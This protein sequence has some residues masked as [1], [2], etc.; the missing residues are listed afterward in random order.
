MKKSLLTSFLLT[1]MMILGGATSWADE[2]SATLDHTAGAQWGSNTGASTVDAEKEHYNNDAAGSWAGCAYAKFSFAIP[3]GHSIT[4]AKLTYS[5]NQGGKSGRNDIIYYM[6]KDFDLDWANFAGQTG[7]DLRNAGSRAGKAVASAATG[8]TGDRLNLQQDVTDAVKAIYDAGQNYIIFQWTGNA[9]GADLYGKTSAN[10]PTLVITTA[11]A[12]SVTTYTVKFTDGTNDLKDAKV[13]EGV[14]IG[15]EQTASANDMASFMANDKKWIYQ[16]GNETITTVADAASNVIT[17]VF[18]EA[19]T[20]NYSLTDATTSTVVAQGTGFEADVIPAYYPHYILK[21]NVLYECPK[22][23]SNPWYGVNITL[24]NTDTEKSINYTATDIENVVFVSEGEAL[25]GASKNTGNY[26]DIRSFGGCVG[27]AATEDIVIANLP[28]GKYKIK[29][30]LFTPTSAMGSQKIKVGEQVLTLTSTANGYH[31]EIETEEFELAAAT[32]IL[33][34]AGGSGTN[35]VDWLYIQKTGDYEAPDDTTPLVLTFPKYNDASVGSYTAEWTANVAGKVWTFNGFNNNSNKWAYV[36][37]GRKSYE[38]V[39]T[40]TSPAVNAVIKNVVFTVDATA[41]VTEAGLTILN[42]DVQVD[43]INI[44]DKFAK[45]DVVI[46]VDGAKGYAYKLTVNSS[47]ASANG[48]TQ[49]SK[50]A[51]YA[52]GEYVADEPI[53]NTLE[54]A[55][56]V[57]KAIELIDAGKSLSDT[58]Y[59]KGVVKAITEVSIEHNNATFA[60]ADDPATEVEMT[61]FRGVGPDGFK[62]TEETKDVLQVSDTVI[63][64]GLLQK[65]NDAYQFTQG[66][67]IVYLYSPVTLAA[68]DSLKTLIDEATALEEAKYTAETWADL[69]T[70]ITAAQTAQD[71]QIGTVSIYRNAY[72]AL[73]AA[74][75]A[76][77]A[78][79]EEPAVDD[80]VIDL[81]ADMFFT[82]DGDG[83]DAVKTSNTPATVDFKLGEEVAAGT[84]IVGTGSVLYLTYADITGATKLLFEGKA[85][86]A[87][88]VLMNRQESNSG[89]LVEKTLSIADNGKAELD[90]TDLPYVHINAIKIPY[91]GSTGNVITSIKFVKPGDP[92]ALPKEALKNAIGAAKL[93]NPVAKTE[94]SYAAL[95]AAILAAEAALNAADA[96]ETSLAKAK[97]GLEA[98]QAALTLAEGYSNLTKD[99]FFSHTTQG[100]E[101]TLNAGCA[102]VLKETSGLP[103]GLST[104][105]WL[106]YADLSAY[107]KLYITVADGAPRFCF[108]RIENGGQ[109]N[110]D[111][112]LSKMID[113]PNN[114]RSTAAYQ[115]VEGKTYIIDLA[116]MVDDKG[117]SYLHC[118]K[119][120]NYGNVTITGMYLYKEEQVTEKPVTFDFKNSTHAA[121]QDVGNI[122]D[123][124]IEQDGVVLSFTDGST[125]TR[126]WGSE[127]N[128][129]LR[130]YKN[131]GTMKVAAPE[132]KA[133]TNIEFTCNSKFEFTAKPE[134]LVD[135]TW[136]GNSTSVLFTATN[137]TQLYAM[138]VTLADKNAETVEPAEPA[139]DE[140]IANTQETAYT[141]AKAMELIDA[142]KSLSDTVFV[143]G[144]IKEIVKVNIEENYITFVIA[145]DT[146]STTTL[147][148]CYRSKCPFTLTEEVK[149]VLQLGDSVVVK[150]TLLKYNDEYELNRDNQIVYLYS[151]VTKAA[152]DSLKTLIDEATALEEAKYTAETWADL[153]TAITAAQTAQDAQIGTVSIYRNAYAT[154]KAAIDALEAKPEVTHTWDFTKWSEET[155]TNLKADA[156]ASK[157][158]GWSDIEKK[159]VA[160][161]DGEPTDLSRDNCF[162]FA[163]AANDDNELTANGVVIEE[164]K[165]LAFDNATYNGKRSL[166]IAV[167]YAV[168]DAAKDFGPYHGPSYLWLGGGGKSIIP[169][170]TIKNVKPGTEIKMGVESHKITDARGVQL[171]ISGA[172]IDG[173]AAPTTYV[174]QTW[175]IPAGEA[176][177]DVVV[178]NTNGCHIYFI[179][180]EI[181]EAPIVDGISTLKAAIEEGTVYNLNGQKVEKPARG[182]YII[183]GKKVVIK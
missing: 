9:G 100:D 148:K 50:V 10:A 89:P 65:Y 28:A 166:A 91:N 177:V 66:N 150:G 42:G 105:D 64:K 122:G 153:Q 71:A 131:G 63:V 116:K 161:A 142:G 94:E 125:K 62:F 147:L 18:R 49:I 115:T 120:A 170:F 157:T 96:T 57:A 124:T 127:G 136:T 2:V 101:G 56:T 67:Q 126:F 23:G 103:Y 52:D 130:I 121:G 30:D 137:T 180:A 129:D 29:A 85:G 20:V 82:W 68:K 133:I 6:A 16:S 118:I 178:Q 12:S 15:S 140:P 149:D 60:I 95:Q 44:T 55:Y 48:P 167:N 24:G 176:V 171:L 119:G 31:N 87:L 181:G 162:W 183:N 40:I 182:L 152:K 146:T 51:L 37:C 70:A 111:E 123:E 156:A 47:A 132:N 39:A 78:K 114:S 79:A 27:Y 143:A 14:A 106:N 25:T 32:D 165:G 141:V 21:E 19:A 8:G 7:T 99:L 36:K 83:A 175:T 109:D 77:E 92:L 108:N 45:G 11:D 139:V 174:E 98:A 4:G 72:A 58:V 168:V 1:L 110:D 59:V 53:A 13:Y 155:V 75:D 128:K 86:T 113:I 26:A 34:A 159:D 145:D 104:V 41:N 5:V 163:G 164:L 90:L 76:L 158:S 22:Q 97:A 35:A 134:G 138:T 154:L 54:T 84:T 179:D 172:A 151:P 112:A 38:S 144:K 135:L 46:A 3:S 160:E 81:T 107:S 173:P 43:S 33:L 74:I 102:Y 73:K 17:L 93:E 117:F 88:R 61:C 80:E 169:C 69:Q